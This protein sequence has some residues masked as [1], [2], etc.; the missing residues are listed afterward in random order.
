MA[1]GGGQSR[2]EWARARLADARVAR[3]GTTGD[4][5]A[6]HLV[7]ITFA[8]QGGRILTAVDHKPKTTTDLRRIRNIRANPKVCVLVD[9][10]DEDWT[11]LWWVRAD[12]LATVLRDEDERLPA[13]GALIAKYPQYAER[14]PAGPVIAIDVVRYA[15]WSSGEGTTPQG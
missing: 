11:R 7:P 2:E 10:Y 13:L 5:L 6:P 4:D 9:H 8:V 1:E 12:G 14:P 15:A 3:L